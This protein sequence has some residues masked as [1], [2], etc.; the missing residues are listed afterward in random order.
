MASRTAMG[1]VIMGFVGFFVKLIFIPINNIIGASKRS[2]WRLC[3][4]S[5]PCVRFCSDLT[6][7]SPSML[8]HSRQHVIGDERPLSR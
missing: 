1:F 3:C 5:V 7:L 6:L 2:R 4:S 8:T